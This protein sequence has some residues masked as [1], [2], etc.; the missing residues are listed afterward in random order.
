MVLLNPPTGMSVSAESQTG[1]WYEQT[2]ENAAASA[3]PVSSRSKTL[4]NDITG[5]KSQRLDTSAPRLDDI[6][7]SSIHQRLQ[8][9]TDDHRRTLNPA[10]GSPDDPLVDD[11][12]RLLGISWQQISNDPDIA[13]A[14]RGWKKFIDNQYSSHLQD[15][16]ILMKNRAL[17]AFLVSARPLGAASSAFY[18]FTEDLTQGQLVGSTWE[19]TLQN[20]RTVP[21]VFEGSD[22]LQAAGKSVDRPLENNTV[23]YANP[24]EAGLPLLQTISA[25]PAANG[26]DLNV[27]EGM[28]SGME[29]D[30]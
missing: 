30:S 28:G 27:G 4:S 1:T 5:R 9:T 16:R 7:L 25:H 6:A 22:V 20:L 12:T 18:L 14:V 26:I 11:A 2:S 29:V 13:A 3:P 21:I 8:N 24:S 17:D 15:S 23:F 10:N 19:I